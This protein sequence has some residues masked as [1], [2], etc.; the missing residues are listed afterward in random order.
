[1]VNTNIG[2]LLV[3][4][5]ILG[6]SQDTSISQT[7]SQLLGG[8][9]REVFVAEIAEKYGA[10]TGWY[11]GLIYTFQVHERLITG[12][13]T[14]FTGQVDDVFY[15]NRDTVIQFHSDQPLSEFGRSF[16]FELECSPAVVDTI[17]TRHAGE[18]DAWYS[19]LIDQY[20]VVADVDEVSKPEFAVFAE[21]YSE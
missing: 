1:M 11:E 6:C 13:P 8:L 3:I 7:S 12:K 20:V 10:T 4:V 17:V 14:L 19:R 5:P 9:A 2:H 18:A 21:P 16:V 15:R